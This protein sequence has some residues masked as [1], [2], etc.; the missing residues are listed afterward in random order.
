MR[1]PLA[2]LAV[3]AA[4]IAV[5]APAGANAPVQ[6]RIQHQIHGC[7]AWSVANGAYYPAQTVRVH[8]GTSFV[9]TDN[10]VMSHT[11]VQLAGPRVVLHAPRMGHM[12]AKTELTLLKPGTYRFTTKPGEDYPGMAGMKTIG[13]DNVLRLMV[14]VV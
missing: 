8:A 5:A 1:F 13:E 9:I 10:D 11:L 2:L 4:A 3:A 14:V 6:I 12:G 7:H